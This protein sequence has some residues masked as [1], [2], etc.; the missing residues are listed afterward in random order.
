[1]ANDRKVLSVGI[2]VEGAEEVRKTLEDIGQAGSDAG[3]RLQEAFSNVNLGKGLTDQ[4]GKALKDLGDIGPAAAKR[5]N[6]ALARI[7][8]GET[9]TARFARMKI[10]F[11]EAG[12]ALQRLTE[13]FAGIRSAFTTFS[14]GISSIEAGLSRMV[15]TVGI[16]ALAIGGFVGGLMKV[17][18]S[19]SN[20]AEAID[21]QAKAFGLTFAEAQKLGNVIR[22]VG[23]DETLLERAL[24]KFT[25]GLNDTGDAAK[26]AQGNIEKL[27][28]EWVQSANA[29]GTYAER[30]KID[31]TFREKVAKETEKLTKEQTKFNGVT[32][33]GLPGLIEYANRLNSLG[34]SQA[35]LAQVTRDFGARGAATMLAF[36]TSIRAEFDGTTDAALKMLPALDEIGQANLKSLDQA[37]DRLG[38]NFQRLQLLI[39]SR[40]APTFTALFDIVREGVGTVGPQIAEALGGVADSLARTIL[41]N[42][43]QII[44]FIKTMGLE[45]VNFSKFVRESLAGLSSGNADNWIIKLK[46]NVVGT[47]NF[48]KGTITNVLIPAFETIAWALEPVAAGINKL[49]GTD[50]TGTSLAAAAA[51]L[52]VSGGFDLLTGAL[53][54]AFSPFKAMY[55]IAKDGATWWKLSTIYIVKFGAAL[56]AA[57]VWMVAFVAVNPELVLLGLA[58]VAVGGGLAYLATRQTEAEKAAA[59]HA[60]AL[61]QLKD[62]NGEID[63]GLDGSIEKL[64]KWKDAQLAAGAAAIQ[65]AEAQLVVSQQRLDEL[66]WEAAQVGEIWGKNSLLIREA[67][68]RV[69]EHSANLA[70]VKRNLAEQMSGYVDAKKRADQLAASTN[71]VAD[72]SKRAA[73]ET[74]QLAEGFKRIVVRGPGGFEKAFDVPT[75]KLIQAQIETKKLEEAL[76]SPGG[77][78]TLLDQASSR[79]EQFLFRVKAVAT[80]YD[81]V[82]AQFT[83][84]TAT[85]QGAFE[86]A[87]DAMAVRAEASVARIKAALSSIPQGGAQAAGQ[88]SIDPETFLGPFR[89]AADAIN[90]VWASLA[91][92]VTAT[93]TSMT[94]SLVGAW[95]GSLPALVEIAQTTSTGISAAFSQI[96]TAGIVSAIQALAEAFGRVSQSIVRDWSDAMR[97]VVNSTRSMTSAVSSLIDGLRSRLE[98]LLRAIARARSQSSEGGA[99]R[100]TG[101]FISGPGT[102]TSDSIMARLSNGEFVMTARAVK[103]WGIDFMYALNNLRM[104]QFA[105]GGLAQ[106][107][108]PSFAPSFAA[109]AMPRA[110]GDAMRP[111]V[112]NINGQAIE[113]GMFPASALAQLGKAAQMSRLASGGRRPAWSK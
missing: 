4:V 36:L 72:A 67:A 37:S 27:R 106:A 88:P 28:Q 42:K 84:G 98:S 70:Q 17:A 19:A 23:G 87:F 83:S 63:A 53:K 75:D 45:F 13:S 57:A 60:D 38:T 49:F 39:G 52:K 48:I 46:D 77:G 51:I 81:G 35:Q 69:R 6:D 95:S 112:I 79:A 105:G 82:I 64:E 85:L 25:A 99:G 66:V 29:A 12:I 30:M 33:D 9:L 8:I 26:G 2:R 20:T 10:A 71:K 78:N 59:A 96:G 73:G 32:Q 14:N 76:K 31:A 111:A 109:S 15:K 50:F 90:A 68:D 92:S 40:L 22:E 61:Q 101:G 1:M 89:I 74:N 16:A 43:D 7:G 5:I 41:A 102:G 108:G 56:K 65:F 34:N 113:G 47:I 100:A 91:Q 94:A 44:D 55:Y 62:I 93:F 18:T 11:S 54:V 80:A 103:R 21:K 3:K 58:L 24:T 104:P 107:Y 86:A 110:R 97:G